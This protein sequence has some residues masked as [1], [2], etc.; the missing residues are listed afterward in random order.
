ME[1]QVGVE[2]DVW[3]E[4]LLQGIWHSVPNLLLKVWSTSYKV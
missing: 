4:R 1:A 2:G 3:K